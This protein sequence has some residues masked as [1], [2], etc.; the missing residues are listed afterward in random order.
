MN[1]TKTYRY[2]TF[3]STSH[4]RQDQDFYLMKT[5]TFHL[6][7]SAL[8]NDSVLSTAHCNGVNISLGLYVTRNLI[9]TQISE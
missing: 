1:K 9:T 6:K 4:L 3:V 8:L 7:T 2:K 5:K